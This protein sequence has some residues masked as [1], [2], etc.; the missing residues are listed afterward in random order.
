MALQGKGFFIWK[1]LSCENGNA[2]QI[3]VLAQEAQLTHVLIKIADTVYSYNVDDGIDRVPS[4]VH[5]LRSRGIQVYGWHYVKGDNPVGEANKAV[6][7]V[8]QL[9]LDGYVIDAEAEYKEPGK[10]EAARKFMTLVRNGLPDIPIALSSYRYPSY[11]PQLPWREFLEKCDLNMP[12]V[13]WMQAHNA[14][15]QLR[16][17]VREFQAMAPF[18]PIVP[19]GAAFK[20]YGWKPAP[21][22][23]KDFL[24]TAQS[25]N[26]TSANFY[27][28]DSS[29]ATVQGL[30]EIWETIRDYS[31]GTPTTPVDITNLLINALNT[32]NPDKVVNLYNPTAVHITAART[33]QGHAAIRSWYQS[34]FNQLL[35]NAVFTLTGFTGSDSS[36]HFTWT[37]VSPQ[38]QVQNGN[39]T[40]GLANGKIAYHYSFFNISA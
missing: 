18:R 31:W 15:D 1:I 12:Q 21:G 30:P 25:L 9:K 37:A 39:D 22:E 40:L 38:G 17:C 35:P 4:L 14:G 16:R 7:R 11:H 33:I 24:Q 13:Y 8:R 10:A 23:V 26:L 34:M 3:A 32:R 28:W 20:E 6:Q 5:A 2:N 36:R 29:R 27:S 19:T